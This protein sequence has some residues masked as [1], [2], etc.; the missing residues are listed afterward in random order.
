MGPAIESFR[1]RLEIGTSGN[2]PDNVP[3]AAA[4]AVDANGKNVS[5]LEQGQFRS[6]TIEAL[7]ISLIGRQN[8]S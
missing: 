5:V 3:N 8:S 7:T 6:H 4:I 2:G 1:R